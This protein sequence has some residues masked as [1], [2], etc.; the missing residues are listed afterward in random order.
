MIYLHLLYL[1]W[2]YATSFFSMLLSS[3][4]NSTISSSLSK[5]YPSDLAKVW[6]TKRSLPPW[7]CRRGWW[8]WT[9][10]VPLYHLM[11]PVHLV[12]PCTIDVDMLGPMMSTT[13]MQSSSFL[14]NWELDGLTLNDR[15]AYRTWQSLVDEE[16]LRAIFE[17]MKLKSLILSYHLTIRV[18][19]TL[20][21]PWSSIRSLILIFDRPPDTNC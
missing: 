12:L 15:A 6:W 19:C 16:V 7:S 5:W 21:V 13:L 8:S 20:L 18:H 1:N 9:P 2:H 11:T 17:V 4:E 10:W 14:L 3:T